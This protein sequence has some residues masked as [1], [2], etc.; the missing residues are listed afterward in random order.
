M[1]GP[2]LVEGDAAAWERVAERVLNRREDLGLTRAKAVALATGV[3]EST[4]GAL[5]RCEQTHYGKRKLAA[6][7]RALG[8]SSNS[9][10][11]IVQGGEPIVLD[12]AGRD[13]EV[14]TRTW[15]IEGRSRQ[16][17]AELQSLSAD[18]QALAQRLGVIEERI[19]RLEE[20]RAP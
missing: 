17:V 16:V 15:Q 3:S 10:E 6:I 12:D 4:W 14:L 18:L 2:V 11:L 9:I 13:R 5:E 8:W 20:L 1:V 19:A 7:S